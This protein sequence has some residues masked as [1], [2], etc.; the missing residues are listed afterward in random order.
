[1]RLAAL[2]TASLLLASPSLALACSVCFDATDENR[3]AFF[4]ATVLLT[5]LPLLIIGSGV[6]WI[7]KQMNPV[8]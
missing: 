6:Y 8:G 5:M 2:T 3:Q 1:M 4:D 7:Y